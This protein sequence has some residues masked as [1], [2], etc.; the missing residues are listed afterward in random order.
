LLAASPVPGQNAPAPVIDAPTPAVRSRAWV[1]TA[2]GRLASSAALLALW[3]LGSSAGW[4]P[5]RVLASPFRVIV[6]G[7][8]LLGSGELQ[9]HFLV[10]LERAAIGL[11]LGAS[12]G[13]SLAVVAGLSRVGEALVDAPLQML[14]TLPVLA[15]VPLF[16]LWFGIGETPKIGLVALATTFPLYVN[17]HAG[18]RGV[19][20]RL[21]EAAQSYGLRGAGLAW[22]VILPGALP[23][24]LVGLRYALG[25]AW[26]VLVVSE[27]I[28]ADAG[29]GFLMTQAREFLRTEI[30]LVG[31][32]VYGAL[33][34]T[35][36]LSVRALEHGLL[37]WRRGFQGT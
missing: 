6:A 9:R 35:T 22:H 15:L 7:S 31:L 26:L 37:R 28:N 11:A 30:I 25:I 8:E 2:A 36:D 34:L 14:R 3:Q 10:S 33:G 24:L 4:I 29:L 21:V 17:V 16:I 5:A 18:I 13:I 19:D 20:Q 1:A 32:A 12:A 23:S 27:Q